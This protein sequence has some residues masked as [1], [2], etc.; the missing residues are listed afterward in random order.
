MRLL[1]MGRGTGGE[2]LWPQGDRTCCRTGVVLEKLHRSV[3]CPVSVLVRLWRCHSSPTLE[4]PQ[5]AQE[6]GL[7]R[8]AARLKLRPE[9]GN[10]NTE[11]G[12]LITGMNRSILEPCS[13]L[14]VQSS[15]TDLFVL[16]AWQAPPV[17][18]SRG[19]RW[20]TALPSI[21][22]KTGKNPPREVVPGPPPPFPFLQ[23]PG[24]AALL[25]FALQNDDVQCFGPQTRLSWEAAHLLPTVN[26]TLT[27]HE[28]EHHVL[29][30]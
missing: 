17:S 19:I 24:L 14:P 4:L 8:E 6:P 29:Q 28:A 7:L 9:V 13:L 18:F 26:V 21:A 16:G 3:P 2:V 25:C 10:V 11:R 30:H 23:I 27:E 20:G 5:T 1:V 12:D 22:L 15:R